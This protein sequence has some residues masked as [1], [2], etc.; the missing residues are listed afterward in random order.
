MSNSDFG[1][2]VAGTI[3]GSD[4]VLQ[5]H[6]HPVGKP[7]TD[8]SQLGIF[9]SK[10]PANKKDKDKKGGGSKKAS[11]GKSQGKTTLKQTVIAF[12]G[13]FAD[14]EHTTF[15]EQ[16]LECSG[17]TH[18]PT[19][20]QR[21]NAF[22]Q[23]NCVGR[24]I[25]R[26]HFVKPPHG[27]NRT[28]ANGIRRETIFYCRQIVTNQQRLATFVAEVLKSIDIV[29]QPAGSAGKG[30]VHVRGFRLEYRCLGRKKN[31]VPNLHRRQTD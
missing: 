10:K 7:E 3:K 16:V 26:Q 17:R 28:A 31:R 25:N 27:M 24:I 23:R 13:Q 4:L 18:R 19:S 21:R 20:E 6:Y 9:F 1:P 8:Q 14:D 2:G 15:V 29:S 22:A 30:I 11:E 5:V 12:A